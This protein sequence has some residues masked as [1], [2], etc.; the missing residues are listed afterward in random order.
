MIF[1]HRIFSS[2]SNHCS[3]AG[4]ANPNWSLGR[5]LE[6]LTKIFTFWVTIRQ[7]TDE[8]HPNYRKIADFRWTSLLCK[9][10]FT[11]LQ[12]IFPAKFFSCILEKENLAG[13]NLL[14]KRVNSTLQRSFFHFRFECGPQKFVSGPRVGHP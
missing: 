11:L 10:E 5:N 8:I 9:V 2:S 1:F 7:K 6:N 4:V 3:N 14:F 12:S 13:K